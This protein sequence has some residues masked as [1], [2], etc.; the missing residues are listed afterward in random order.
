MRERPYDRARAGVRRNTGAAWLLAVLTAIG[1]GPSM[2]GARASAAEGR[3]PNIV[4]IFSDDH[5]YQAISAYGDPRKLIETPQHRPHREGGDAVRPLRRARTRSAGRA[6]P[7]SSP[8]STATST[9]S[10]TTPTAASTARRPRSPSCCRR[11]AT[12]PRSS[13][14]GTSS[15]TR[16]ASTTGTSCPGQGRLLQPADDPATASGS[17]TRATSPTSSPTSALDWL[18]NRDKSKPFLLM[19]QHKAPHR[20]WAPAL[21][22]L[23]PRQATASTPSRRRCS[24]TT[25]AAA[26]R[27]RDQDMTIAKTFT[28]L[29]LKLTP[30][31]RLT[32]EQRKAWDAYY[33]PRNEAFRE[34]NS[35]ARTSS[36]G[37]TTATC[38]TTSA[39]SRRW[40]RASAGCSSTSTTRGWRRTR[41]SS[42]ASDQG[43]YLGEH[44]WFDKRWIFEESLRTPL[45][46]RWPGVTKP[47]SVE[48]EPRLAT[49]TSPQTFLDAAGVP[50]PAEMQGRS[51]VPLLK[52][53]TPGGLAEELLLPL[54]RVPPAAPRPPALRRRDRPLQAGPLLQAR[55]GLLGAV[56]PR[57]GP[58]GAAER[59]RRPGQ[60]ARSWRTEAGDGP[61]ARGAEGPGDPPR[62]RTAG[63]PPSKPPPPGRRP[64]SRRSAGRT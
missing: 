17:S 21:R 57:E 49:S 60:C 9:A 16:P 50:V 39:A 24:T 52:G 48:R 53:E 30:P 47:G 59:V 15:A 51:L 14:S 10:T 2:P 28:P 8:A 35:R 55:R 7:R 45:L 33:E 1:L 22:H 41:S 56:R 42:T 44:G 34:A 54:L 43:F 26:R 27:E 38:T 29:D 46:V 61:P 3:R 6:G 4:F 32:P 20:E 40:T 25:P 5:A 63:P 64:A 12:R 31:P 11:P 23:G 58:A 62:R 36:A 13:A 18:K 37:S 19:C